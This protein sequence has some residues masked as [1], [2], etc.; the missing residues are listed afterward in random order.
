MTIITIFLFRKNL[1]HTNLLFIPCFVS[2]LKTQFHES[3]GQK[4]ECEEI[5]QALWSQY[6]QLSLIKTLSTLA[7]SLPTT[8]SVPLHRQKPEKLQNFD[9]I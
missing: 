3:P 9:N 5:K 8:F 4:I 7:T 2:R 6:S 1:D